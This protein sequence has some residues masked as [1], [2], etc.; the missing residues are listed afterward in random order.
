MVFG[1]AW[2]RAQATARGGWPD[3]TPGNSN[4]SRQSAPDPWVTAEKTAP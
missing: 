2:V 1:L 3:G 4:W